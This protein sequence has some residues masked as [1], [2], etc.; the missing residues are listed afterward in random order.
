M[1]LPLGIF[2]LLRILVGMIGAQ[3]SLPRVLQVSGTQAGLLYF[4]C[5][6]SFVA[7]QAHIK[8][9]F[10]LKMFLYCYQI[11]EE[12]KCTLI[13]LCKHDRHDNRN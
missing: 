12:N 9:N 7:G 11:I 10:A 1:V 8:I 5:N 6:G 2:G 13:Q 3:T 4:S